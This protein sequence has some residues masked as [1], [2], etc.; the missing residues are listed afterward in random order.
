MSLLNATWVKSG[1]STADGQPL[2]LDE[3]LVH[4][5]LMDTQADTPRVLCVLKEGSL[6]GTKMWIPESQIKNVPFRSP[7]YSPNSEDFARLDAQKQLALIERIRRRR[8]AENEK[9]LQKKKERT[10]KRTDPAKALMKQF[11]EAI[12]GV[13]PTTLK[14]LEKLVK[15][16]K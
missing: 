16:S 9:R 11:A 3:V 8:L 6:A 14:A 12:K 2:P 15:E 7:Q 4:C 1:G 5:E 10:A 13:D